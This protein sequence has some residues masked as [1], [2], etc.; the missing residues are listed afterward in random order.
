M[1]GLHLLRPEQ[2]W[3][4]ARDCLDFCTLL[5]LPLETCR[6]R[7]VTRKIAAGRPP[8]DVCA[9]FRRVDRPTLQEQHDPAR[10][11]RADLVIQLEEAEEEEGTELRTRLRGCERRENLVESVGLRAI[12]QGTIQLLAV[13]L[14]PALQK[15]LVFDRWQRG[16]VNRTGRSFGRS[17]G[18]A[19]SSRAPRAI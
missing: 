13:G 5:E 19:S 4:E 12:P 16:Q 17:A 9:A 18:K 7:V 11:A 2:S 1:E 15:T 6:R 14:N 10:R 3:K 8:A